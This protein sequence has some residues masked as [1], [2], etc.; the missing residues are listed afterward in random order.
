MTVQIDV[1]EA[2][3]PRVAPDRPGPGAPA[4][5]ASRKTRNFTA[6]LL[7]A[8][9]ESALTRAL[10]DRPVPSAPAQAPSGVQDPYAT[11]GNYGYPGAG[12]AAPNPDYGAPLIPGFGAP[13]AVPAV[14]AEY[15]PQGPAYGRADPSYGGAP[16]GG[17][18]PGYDAVNYP[19]IP[20]LIA[21]SQRHSSSSAPPSSGFGYGGAAGGGVSGARTPE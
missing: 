14:P 19:S 20:D 9:D 10:T 5:R 13:P 21:H 11:Q 1:S 15:P 3:K 4:P 17:N 6:L 7:G 16:P 12:P 18:Q 2:R 8:D